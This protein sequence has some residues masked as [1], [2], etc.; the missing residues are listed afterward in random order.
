MLLILYFVL[1]LGGNFIGW[2]DSLKSDFS[3]VIL[4]S[5]GKVLRVTLSSD[6]KY[7]LKIP[8]S[9]HPQDIKNAALLKE[10]R[11]F[12]SHPGVNPFALVRSFISTLSSDRMYGGSTI[13]MQTA[14][15]L[16]KLRTK[17][18]HGKINQIVAALF[19]EF[20]LSKDEI[21]ELY[22]NHIPMGS[23]IEGIGAASLIYFNKKPIELNILES[24]ALLEIPQNPNV[25]KLQKNKSWSI[26]TKTLLSWLKVFPD[27][28][29]LKREKDISISSKSVKDLPFLAPHFTDYIL[30]QN[31]G[32]QTIRTSLDYSI[33]KVF[34]SQL[35]NYIRLKKNIGVK[36]GSILLM[37]TKTSNIISMVGSV[38]FFNSEISGQVNGVISK[39]SPGSTLKPLVYALAA[40]QGLIHSHS[41]L[42]D[43]P[44]SFGL[45]DPENADRAYA[46]PITAI[47]ALNSSRNVPAVFLTNKLKSPDLYDVLVKAYVTRLKNKEFYGHALSL[48]GVE[49]TMLEL[50]NLYRMLLFDESI[51]SKDASSMVYEMMTQNNIDMNQ[52]YFKWIKDNLKVAWKTGTSHGFRDAWTIGFVGP[53]TLVVW[54]G[55]FDNSSNPAFIGRDLAAPLFFNLIN[56]MKGY[57][58]DKIRIPT[59][60]SNAEL[61]NEKVCSLSGDLPSANCPYKSHAMFIPGKSSIKTCTLHRRV[62]IDSKTGQRECQ[63]TARSAYKVYEFWPSQ[64]SELFNKFGFKRKT[65]PLFPNQCKDNNFFV[66]GNK[67]MIISPRSYMKYVIN[68][69]KKE[70]QSLALKAN[71]DN[72]VRE[73]FWF[74]NNE[75]LGKSAPDDSLTWKLKNGKHLIKVVD[76]HGRFDQTEIEVQYHL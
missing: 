23:N 43:I 4:D 14:R 26:P 62:A 64:V 57:G 25:K 71:V 58:F 12:Y 47:D 6:E 40:D 24:I 18:V 33:Q 7:R 63:E 73:L 70:V 52:S 68:G 46:G 19:L 65:P 76:D 59:L 66:S 37:E 39:R 9:D 27:E 74:L 38:D 15:L 41:L 2:S 21:L 56:S 22:L 55:N 61:K 32:T 31:V 50:A 10:D 60:L 17:S 51:F 45:F 72:D 69:S 48:G 34:E 75:Y 28:M 16:F 1:A 49:V 67:P 30:S 44:Q 42:F 8:L 11:Y 13:T 36:N 53:Y 3:K 29:I 35:K 5:K 54:L 20:L